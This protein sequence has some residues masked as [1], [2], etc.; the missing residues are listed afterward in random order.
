MDEIERLRW[1]LIADET[2]DRAFGEVGAVGSIGCRPK[3][4]GARSQD[5]Y[6][7]APLT[8]MNRGPFAFNRR[9]IFLAIVAQLVFPL[10]IQNARADLDGAD[11]TGPKGQTTTG[12][13]YEARCGI[14]KERCKVGFRDE[15]LLI[16][17]GKGIE[18]SQFV[19]VVLT[20]E[21]T[22][23]SL[24]FPNITSCFQNQLDWDFTITYNAT[25]GTRRSALISF[26]PRYLNTNPTDLA[27]GFV[28]D[29]QVWLKDVIR[30]I[31]PSIQLD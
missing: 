19:S 24:L 6:K 30:P 4:I 2:I 16:N 5:S 23:R 9:V 28:R 13:V 3:T 17:D 14:K 7:T 11:I 10:W 22:Q 21:C 1:Q 26:M 31:G 8:I 20:R 25:D 27:R 15:R 29:L 18:R 12:E